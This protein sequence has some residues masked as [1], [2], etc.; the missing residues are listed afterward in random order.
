MKWWDEHT[1]LYEQGWL[2]GIEVVNNGEFYPGAVDW[3]LEKGLT[4]LGNSDQ[5]APFLFT[6]FDPDHHRP[7]TLV[8]AP[9]RTP[10]GIREALF[11]GRTA[12]FKGRNLIGKPAILEALFLQ[13]VSLKVA[14]PEMKKYVLVN[15]TDLYFEIILENKVTGKTE[16]KILLKPAYASAFELAPES[17]PE[18]INVR[19]KNCI[20]GSDACLIVKLG[21]LRIES[22]Q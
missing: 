1:Y 3:A 12:V 6:E 8:F 4:M 16:E 15:P 22:G 21:N 7:M 17:G 18:Q 19:V 11:N 10:G 5:H 2:H 13:A 9:E 14:D 20:V